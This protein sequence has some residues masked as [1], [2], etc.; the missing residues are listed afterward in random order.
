LYLSQCREELSQN[1]LDFQPPPN[2]W[3]DISDPFLATAVLQKSL[4]RGDRLYALG[5]ALALLKIDAPRLWRR[6]VIAVCEDFGLSDLGFTSQVIAAASDKAWRHR[7]GGDAHI[8]VYMIYRLL[9]LAR[10][11][12][13]DE[14]YML[15]VSLSRSKNPKMAVKHLRASDRL[16]ELL[17]LAIALVLKCE[18]MIPYRGIRAVIAAECDVA[19]AR[20]ARKGWADRGLEAVC[21]Q[22]RRTSQCLLPVLLP[23]VKN[24]SEKANGHRQILM[25]EMPEFREIEGL[26]SYSLDGYTRPGRIALM[27]L[28]RQDGRLARFLAPLPTAKARMD[29]LTNLLFVAEGGVCTT[30]LSDP[31]YDELKSF[32]LGCWTGLPRSILGEGL[33]IMA[34]ALPALNRIRADLVGTTTWKR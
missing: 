32:S 29:A 31:L 27:A 8:A 25:R 18:Q 6:L 26:P 9:D 23:L 12:R 14:L 16:S 10:D 17:Q 13:V 2:E 11:R 1:L 21:M 20:M 22:A 28:A 33:A 4:R 24:A 3:L 5:A 30:E 7:C 15:A 34:S 19:I